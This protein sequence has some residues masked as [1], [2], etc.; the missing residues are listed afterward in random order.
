MKLLI[1]YD[2]SECAEAALDDMCRAGL[3]DVAEALVLSVTEL[4]LPSP[5][6]SSY[7]IV[8]EAL[9]AETPTE[10]QRIHQR[11]SAAVQHATALAGQARER[12]QKNFP[13]WKFDA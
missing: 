1:A 3:P 2:G 4:W 8:E 11:H 10:L 9:L 13:L 7:E 5:P 6:P 12:L